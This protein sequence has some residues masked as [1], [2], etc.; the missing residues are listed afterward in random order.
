MY[1][2]SVVNTK[3]ISKNGTEESHFNLWSGLIKKKSNISL[4]S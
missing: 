2:Y 1:Y 3:I 4:T